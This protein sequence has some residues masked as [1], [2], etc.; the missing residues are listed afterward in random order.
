LVILVSQHACLTLGIDSD[1]E[2][3]L[4]A[5]LAGEQSLSTHQYNSLG[6][7]VARLGGHNTLIQ[8]PSETGSVTCYL[9][10]VMTVL[11]YRDGGYKSWSSYY[12][13]EALLLVECT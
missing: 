2:T 5:H 10:N 12:P 4:Q 1:Q 13:C 7:N 3:H 6:T 11:L 9:F 8:C